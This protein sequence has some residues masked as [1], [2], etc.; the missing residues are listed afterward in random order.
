MDSK[1]LQETKN[2]LV[3]NRLIRDNW[4]LTEDGYKLFRERLLFNREIA[5][6]YKEIIGDAPDLRRRFK[7][8]MESAELSTLS[9]DDDKSWKLFRH[10]YGGGDFLGRNRIN[11]SAFFKGKV[12]INRNELKLFKYIK[13]VMGGTVEKIFSGQ[14][15]ETASNTYD[16]R[17]VSTLL[18]RLG[19]FSNDRLV[20]DCNIISTENAKV[21]SDKV[22]ALLN[23]HLKLPNIEF[24]FHIRERNQKWSASFMGEDKLFFLIVSIFS[25]GKEGNSDRVI[26]FNEEEMKEFLNK[27]NDLV[28]DLIGEYKKPKAKSLELVVSLNP[29][30]WFLCSTGEKWSSCMSLEGGYLFWVGLPL[31]VGDK[32]RALI[33]ITDG[34]KKEYQG[35]VVD[36]F[37][38]RSWGMLLREKKTT[39]KKKNGVKTVLGIVR[40]YPTR[41]GIADLLRQQGVSTEIKNCDTDSFERG[42]KYYGRYY[43]EAIYFGKEVGEMYVTPYQDIAKMYIAK[44]NKAQYKEG[45]YYYY[46]YIPGEGGGGLSAIYRKGGKATKTG[47]SFDHY[48]DDDDDCSSELSTLIENGDT[49]SSLI[50]F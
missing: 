12:M 45:E 28:T 48:N 22:K 25:Y 13:K 2:K 6:E 3:F 11:Y 10:F 50:R 30:D 34:T 43:S 17:F 19:S 26:I 4:G 47:V 44:K 36:R 16:A 14:V 24:D 31:L 37:L 29:I 27:V 7:I 9:M 41:Y 1:H 35:M 32:N 20:R 21:F 15:D 42:E 49:V 23:V 39:K 5:K 38:S 33:Y 8:E 40:E 18:E 46:K